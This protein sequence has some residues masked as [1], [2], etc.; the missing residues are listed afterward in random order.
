MPRLRIT[1]SRELH[2]VLHAGLIR[3]GDQREYGAFLF[4]EPRTYGLLEVV[5]LELLEADQL[6]TQTLGYLE[7]RDGGLQKMILRA[8]KSGTALV[9]A[10]SHPFSVGPSVAFS[11]FD[12]LGLC[13]V[14]PHVSWRLP[15]R[16]YGALVFGRRAFD[17][18]FWSGPEQAPRGAVDLLVGGE[19][20][21]S[22]GESLHR[23]GKLR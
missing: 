19:L 21:R 23:W 18:L 16:P 14:A 11:P 4:A 2:R 12:E 15:G 8:H 5:D 1:L 20:L 22:S 9:E 10:H 3:D 7:L 6:D 13:E 17:G